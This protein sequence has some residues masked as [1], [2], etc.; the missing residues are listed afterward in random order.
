MVL[1]VSYSELGLS[2]IDRDLAIALNKAMELPRVVKLL[3]I[4]GLH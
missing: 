4:L 2:I 3:P 1:P